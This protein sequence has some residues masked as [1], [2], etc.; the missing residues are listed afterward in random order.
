MQF[1]TEEQAKKQ[2]EKDLKE[3]LSKIKLNPKFLAEQ[4]DIIQS[5]RHKTNEMLNLNLSSKVS[6]LDESVS[7]L[8]YKEDLT[9]EIRNRIN[10]VKQAW[11]DTS[12]QFSP[13]FSQ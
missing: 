4:I 6:Q 12:G 8:A 5:N 10:K 13:D 2:A 9:L 1:T 11:R 3:L 7:R